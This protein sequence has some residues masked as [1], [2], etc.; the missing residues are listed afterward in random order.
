MNASYFVKSTI[1]RDLAAPDD[2]R[3]EEVSKYGQKC[4]LVILI[5]WNNWQHTTESKTDNEK[6]HA[7]G[8]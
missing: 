8:Q 2:I 7:S 4:C 5:G 1:S 6:L 3:N